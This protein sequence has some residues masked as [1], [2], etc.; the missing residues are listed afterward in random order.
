MLHD[1][2]EIIHIVENRLIREIYYILIVLRNVGRKRNDSQR[3]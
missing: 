3:V 2:F 1:V